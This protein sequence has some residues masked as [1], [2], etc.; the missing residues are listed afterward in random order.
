MRLTFDIPDEQH[1]ILTRYI[2]HGMRKYTYRALI[3]GFVEELEK[4]PAAVMHR[5]IERQIKFLDLATKGVEDGFN[6]RT[7][8]LSKPDG[9]RE[10]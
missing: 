5:L 9:E 4:D 8:R 3:Q 6:K 2:P 10:D 1:Q 7:E